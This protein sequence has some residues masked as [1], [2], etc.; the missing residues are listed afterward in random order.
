MKILTYTPTLFDNPSDWVHDYS[1]S[2]EIVVDSKIRTGGVGHKWPCILENKKYNLYE[3]YDYLWFIDDDVEVDREAF[4]AYVEKFN[5]EIVQPALA[6]VNYSHK[7]LVRHGRGHRR[8]RFC[9][10]MAPCIRTD[11]FMK[12]DF[13]HESKSGWGLDLIWGNLFNNYVV[14]D[15]VMK[16]TQP[17]SSGSWVIDGLTPHQEMERIIKKWKLY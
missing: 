17:V 11:L 6:P 12:M 9:E 3:N 7:F 10:I 8:V 13:L 5:F 14:D 2:F 16:H 1:K 4:K 15:V